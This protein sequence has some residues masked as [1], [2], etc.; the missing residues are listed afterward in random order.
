MHGFHPLVRE[1]F[2]IRHRNAGFE[3][4]V[5]DHILF[6]FSGFR[7]VYGNNEIPQSDPGSSRHPGYAHLIVENL[8]R[9][10]TP[11]GDSPGV[12]RTF[13]QQ[14]PEMADK[15]AFKDKQTD[16][17]IR[18]QRDA[19]MSNMVFGKLPPQNRDLEEVVL[20][21]LMIDK[22]ALPMVLE[23]LRPETFYVDAHQHIYQAMIQLFDHSKPVDMLTV[24][25]ELRKMGKLEAIG[26]PYTLVELT[27]RVASAANIEYHSRILAQKHIQRELI[28]ISNK[29]IR[30][31]Y[32]DTTDV[33]DLL[34]EAE[35]GL[36]SITQTNISKSYEPLGALSG[37]ALKLIEEL[38][39]KEDGMTGVPSGF[40]D[41]DNLTAGWQP[42]DLIIIAA[43][44]SMGKTAFTLSL[45]R[46]AAVEYGK[47][48]AFFSLEMGS[49]QL[50]MR[51][52][53]AE[54]EVKGDR[55]RN[56]KLQGEQEWERVRS[57]IS[58]FS[59]V[60]I[61]IDDTPAINIFEL[62][63]KC[64]RLRKQHGIEL[65]IIDYLQ[66]MSGTGDS[67]GN[68]EQEVSAISRALKGMA[69]EL[70]IPVIALSQLSR[71]VENRGG[72]KR[73]MLSDLRESGA[74]EQDADIVTFL[75]RPEYYGMYQDDEGRDTTGLT[76]VIV[77]KHRNGAVDTVRLRF[78]KDFARFSDWDD[79]H[80]D[81]LPMP[82]PM[83]NPG[84]HFGVITRSSRMN[85]E[86]VPF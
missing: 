14:P 57:A 17:R 47:P 58:K 52:I 59:D 78:T 4:P 10:D 42:S 80:F 71:N 68:R 25:E 73:P 64:R 67:K 18:R 54:A 8:E 77:A 33:F 21:A 24:T 75:F 5:P 16:P 43:R 53:S 30:D 37:K 7:P 79:L 85:D 82:D 44:P 50:A 56:G 55:L 65:V 28:R 74:I 63:A 1:F 2:H 6:A 49:T 15:P 35:A 19:D 39:Q 46:N 27:N 38:S 11:P 32:E 70:E 12:V 41:L 23:I 34:D 83:S 20:G 13:V 22:E 86:D 26:G 69:K 48:V 60:P 66:L 61:F 3:T 72:I 45:A 76:E 9:P 29:T 40:R 51:L 62:R 81:D 31:A 84:G 36:F